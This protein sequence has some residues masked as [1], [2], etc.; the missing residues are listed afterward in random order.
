[1][2]RTPATAMARDVAQFLMDKKVNP[3]ELTAAEYDALAPPYRAIRMKLYFLTF[4]RA[5]KHV[6]H[7]VERLETNLAKVSVKPAKLAKTP[8]RKETKVVNEP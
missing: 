1:M 7:Q 3:L 6:A 5:M 2:N 4:A 8:V